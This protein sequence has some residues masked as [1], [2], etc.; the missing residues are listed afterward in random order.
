MTSAWI[1]LF[2]AGLLEIAW[3]IGIKYTDGFNFRTRT[4]ASALTLLAM[5]ASMY[6]LAVAI[7]SIPVGT[8]YAIWTGIGALGAATLGIILFQEPATLPRIA[9]LLM[10]VT[11]IVGLKLTTPTASGAIS[12]LKTDLFIGGYGE[13]VYVSSFDAGTGALSE[14]RLIAQVAGASFVAHH[15]TLPMLYA[16]SEAGD[17]AVVALL[18]ESDGVYTE[19]G[20]ASSGGNGP[21]HVS[22][23]PSGLAVFVA[24]YGDGRVAMLRLKPDGSF[25]GEPIVDAHEGGGPNPKRQDRAHAH[26]IYPHPDGQH[27]LSANLGTDSIYLYRVNVE[28]G[29]LSDRRAVGIVPGSGPRHLAF[30]TDGRFIYCLSELANSVTVLRWSEAMLSPLQTIS[31]LP[32]GFDGTS[33]AAEIRLHPTGRFLYSTNRGHD[34]IAVYK[35]D[36]ETGTLAA[37]GHVPTGGAS[38]RG[39]EV[40]PTGRYLLAANQK[41]NVITVF[42]IDPQSGMPVATA[43]GLTVEKPA[44]VR[45]AASAP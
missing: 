3:A 34:T 43:T 41:S 20:R 9:C 4:F 29:E 1:T 16:V 44:C 45:F 33:T 19:T 37:R 24:N 2:I 8:G 12:M 13:G 18:R 40:D 25:D 21:C 39:L 27:V 22:V 36:Q 6:L 42:S 32:E 15:P 17:G 28:R 11:G 31:T 14:P 10:L 35:V 30:S 38:P 7:R 23:H 5:I 26:S